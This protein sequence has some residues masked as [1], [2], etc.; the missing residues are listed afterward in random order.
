MLVVFIGTGIGAGFIFDGK[1]FAVLIMLPGR[2]VILKLKKTVLYADA[3]TMAV[4]KRL[5]AVPL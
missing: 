5:Q 1:L 4:L 2:S 3:V